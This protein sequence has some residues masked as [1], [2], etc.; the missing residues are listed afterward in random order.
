MV[1]SRDNFLLDVTFYT[2]LLTLARTKCE[3]ILGKIIL[4]P[5]ASRDMLAFRDGS[6]SNDVLRVH[7]AAAE[8]L[9]CSQF[10]SST[11]DKEE[12]RTKEMYCD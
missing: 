3:F 1:F 6:R 12:T 4:L 9:A 5:S 11:E 8:M 2:F 10:E 7:L